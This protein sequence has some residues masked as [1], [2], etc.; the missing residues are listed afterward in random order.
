M[1][2]C[3]DGRQHSQQS[4]GTR[5]NSSEP[6]TETPAARTR[7]SSVIERTKPYRWKPGQSGNPSGTAK[8]KSLR[9]LLKEA[10]PHVAKELIRCMRSPDVEQ[11]LEAMRLYARFR[12][13]AEWR[14]GEFP[15]L[16]ANQHPAVANTGAIPVTPEV[17]EL[18]RVIVDAIAAH[19]KQKEVASGASH[20]ALP[21]LC[22][23]PPT[24]QTEPAPAVVENGHSEPLP[25]TSPPFGKW[26]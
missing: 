20:P 8:R 18:K 16:P 23:M 13:F 21:N 1:K 25:P 11:A 19:T 6:A 3:I 26:K 14:A 2:R 7:Y 24:A 12:H 4:Q 22:D 10:D 15:A 5:K 9:M 17:Q